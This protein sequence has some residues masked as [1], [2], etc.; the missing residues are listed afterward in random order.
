[1]P[2]TI[3]DLVVT[4]RDAGHILGS[5][6]IEVVDQKDKKKIV[7]SGDLG[8]TPE[9][10]VRPTYFID[11]A[12]VVVM[13]STYGS[14]SHPDDV[15]TQILQEE[16]NQTEKTGGVL[17]IPAFS[18]E[19]TQEILHRIHHLKKEKK[20]KEDTPVFLDSPMGIRTTIIFRDFKEFYNEELRG[21]TDDPFSFEGLVV[22]ENS[23]DSK[24]IIKAMNPK[25]ILAG[26]G[27]LSGGRILH[28]AANYLGRDTTR[29]LFVGYQS[30]ETLGRKV[31]DGEKKI[32]IDKQHVTVR[33]HIRQIESFSS[34]ADQ[35]KLMN[36][37]KS[38][39]GVQ[40]VFL[41]HG[42]DPQRTALAAKIKSDLKINDIILPKLG[43]SFE[44]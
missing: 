9:D 38:M 26:S 42:E 44:F 35:P 16:I 40:K 6:S 20:I 1:K 28:H 12:D 22:S 5:S 30:E 10:I 7:F 43:E 17:L 25:V 23:R 13:E 34:H 32:M 27:M 18:I 15:P 31:L 36:W 37:L 3:G 2:L 33:A 29:L 19:R 14:S 24:E 4:F 21:H 39:K 8:N 41:I 11:A